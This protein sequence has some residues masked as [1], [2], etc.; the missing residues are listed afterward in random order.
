MIF[1]AVQ[2]NIL[3]NE[4]IIFGKTDKSDITIQDTDYVAEMDR[5]L[6]DDPMDL[7]IKFN[8]EIGSPITV[9]VSKI[10]DDFYV[11]YQNTDHIDLT[12]T[13]LFVQE[14]INRYVELDRGKEEVHD[15]TLA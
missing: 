6:F 7:I 9:S 8:Q 1:T 13:E 14:T 10:S 3:R 5:V 12:K 2:Q 11:L 15:K 4:L